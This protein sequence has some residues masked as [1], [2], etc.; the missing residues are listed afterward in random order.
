MTWLV[1]RAHEVDT[2]RE[3]VEVV[4]FLSRCQGIEGLREWINRLRDPDVMEFTSRWA[5][6]NACGT[7]GGEPTE[8]TRLTDRAI[9]DPLTKALIF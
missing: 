4:Q 7:Y 6:E 9:D 2:G 1:I 3:R 8:L 5:A